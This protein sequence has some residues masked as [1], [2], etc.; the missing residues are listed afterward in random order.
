MTDIG[1]KQNAVIIIL[2]FCLLAGGCTQSTD[3]VGQ[4][5]VTYRTSTQLIFYPDFADRS[6][7]SSEDYT[8]STTFDGVTY[9]WPQG[10]GNF[11]KDSN[12]IT[13]Q[14]KNINCNVIGR[15]LTINGSRIV[16]SKEGDNVRITDGG[17]IFV[18]NIEIKKPGDI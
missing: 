3:S 15:R 6:F 8:I 5:N 9:I 2:M 7:K 17:K 10:E 1:N 4:N 18:N 16:E 13:F 11:S 14:G 12:E